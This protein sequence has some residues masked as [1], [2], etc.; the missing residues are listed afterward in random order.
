MLKNQCEE[1][2]LKYERIDTRDMEIMRDQL[3]MER[4]TLM[5]KLRQSE[6]QQSVLQTNLTTLRTELL[7]YK[8]E[9]DSVRS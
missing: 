4:E 8:I 6:E 1:W 3:M 7:T 2:K 9:I 5:L